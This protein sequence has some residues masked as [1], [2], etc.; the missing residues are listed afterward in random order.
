MEIEEHKRIHKELHAALDQL[1][2]D[3]ISQTGKYPSK[4][5]VLELM[6]WSHQQTINPVEKN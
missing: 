1:V 6:E 4:S 5:T 3:W 2:A